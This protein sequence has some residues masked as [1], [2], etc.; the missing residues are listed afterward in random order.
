MSDLASSRLDFLISSPADH[1]QWRTYLLVAMLLHLLI[2]SIPISKLGG[3]HGGENREIEVS[4]IPEPTPIIKQIKPPV[5]RPLQSPKIEKVK[6]PPPVRLE[7]NKTAEQPQKIVSPDLNPVRE[8]AQAG[9]GSGGVAIVGATGAGATLSGSAGEPGGSGKGL[10]RQGV[11]G[12]GA[13]PIE[14]RFGTGDGPQWVY[15]EKPVY[16]YA[17]QKLGK[18]GR[19]V[20]KLTIDE[21]GNLTKTEV[22]EATDQIFVSSV[23]D[24]VRRSKFRPARR[25][26]VPFATWATWPVVFRPDDQ[27]S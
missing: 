12:G 5:L 17:A 24:A 14:A 2:L 1:P 18:K 15:Q 4:V 7:G 21:K 20:L 16:P 10:G 26:G 11:G 22:M 23:L 25:N 13:G 9:P 19:V 27:S 3:Y 8:V 6:S